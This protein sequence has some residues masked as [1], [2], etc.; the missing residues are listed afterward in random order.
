MSRT[1]FL[2]TS[3]AARLLGVSANTVRSWERRHLPITMFKTEGGHR[4]I[5]R[6]FV[7]A[8]RDAMDE[9]LFASSACTRAAELVETGR[10]DEPR[11]LHERMTKLEGEVNELRAEIQRTHEAL[12]E[13][14]DVLIR[15]V[16]RLCDVA[17]TAPERFQ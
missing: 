11:R 9:G 10:Y 16:E 5:D 4:R 6:K 2:R 14:E 7:L 8:M 1:T 13:R 3:E 15:T 12:L 17:Q